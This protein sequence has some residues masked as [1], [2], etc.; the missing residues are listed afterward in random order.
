M[1]T[2]SAFFSQLQYSPSPLLYLAPMEDI[3]DPSFRF[4]AKEY[5]AD[6]LITEFI[7]SDELVANI[8]RTSKKFTIFEHERPVGIQ[9]YG[10]KKDAMVYAAQMVAEANP[11]FIDINWGCPM[12]K[13]VKRF[14]GAGMLR[15][16][17]L[18]LEITEAVAKSV[19]IPVTVK[20]RLGWDDNSIV[21]HQLVPQLQNTGIKAITVHARTREQ[22][23]SGNADWNHLKLLKENKSIHIPIIGNGDIIDEF[24][25]YNFLQY[26][27]VDAL[28]IGRAT[29]GKPW[30]F[31]HVRHF[32]ETGNLLPSPNTKERVDLCIRLLEKAI[33]W[34]GEERAVKEMRKQYI[35][36]FKEIAD[37]HL[38][39]KE[40]LTEENPQKV[41]SIL[42]ILAEKYGDFQFS[43]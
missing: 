35:R 20:T 37:F 2:N 10:H 19:N 21:I 1:Q 30:I 6:V 13:I 40:L 43:A 31:K 26:S 34:K 9:I 25:A 33:D 22:I 32:L 17:P 16:I 14:A 42:H 23:Y 12:K 28:M 4:I 29:I 24:S 5:G 7:S 18:M 38:Y 11:D 8:E 36:F 41:M 3:T 27:K 39:R 15:N